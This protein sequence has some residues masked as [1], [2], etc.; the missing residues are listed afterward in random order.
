MALQVASRRATAGGT[1]VVYPFCISLGIL[2]FK[3]SSGL[4]FVPDGTNRIVAGLRYLAISLLFGWWGIP[5]GIF[6]TIQCSL[7]CLQG[8][9]DVTPLVDPE[10]A[11]ANLIRARTEAQR[12]APTFRPASVVDQ[13]AVDS[14]SL[15]RAL[16]RGATKGGVQP[17]LGLEALN[18]VRSGDAERYR[19]IVAML[20]GA[21]GEV[22]PPPGADPMAYIAARI[23]YMQALVLQSAAILRPV[24]DDADGPTAAAQLFAGAS[25]DHDRK[26]LAAIAAIERNPGWITELG[27][28]AA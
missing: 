8:G 15:A 22:D 2:S 17:N 23:P 27:D 5:W 10:R 28:A 7:R 26:W 11:A 19:G 6:W 20:C 16:F 14:P 18:A 13:A 24:V 4:V 12:S 3:R 25:A 21:A 9:I 1:W